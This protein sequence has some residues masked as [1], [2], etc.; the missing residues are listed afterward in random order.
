MLTSSI[1]M[2]AASEYKKDNS[3]LL[4]AFKSV[5]PPNLVIFILKHASIV[6]PPEMYVFN[7]SA[8][9]LN[10]THQST[11]RLHLLV[12]LLAPVAFSGQDLPLSSNISQL[13]SGL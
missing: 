12:P 2:R 8:I 1:M 9:Y 11:M 7:Y 4:A 10:S 5:M 6:F 13:K 3:D